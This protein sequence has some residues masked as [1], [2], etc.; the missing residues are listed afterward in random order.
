MPDSHPIATPARSRASWLEV[1]PAGSPPPLAHV[2]AGQPCE[3]GGG[4]GQGHAVVDREGGQDQ[5]PLQ[6]GGSS[7]QRLRDRAGGEGIRITQE[8]REEAGRAAC[9]GGGEDVECHC[10]YPTSKELSIGRVRF[11]AFG[12]DGHQINHSR[13]GPLRQVQLQCQM[14]CKPVLPSTASFFDPKE[15]YLAMGKT[16]SHHFYLTSLTFFTYDCLEYHCTD[17]TTFCKCNPTVA[18]R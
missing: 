17:A 8:D 2:E 5:Q 15:I 3:I 6:A 14:F 12:L 18:L 11:K 1:V 4:G 16:G 9:Q 10:K 7:H 13:F